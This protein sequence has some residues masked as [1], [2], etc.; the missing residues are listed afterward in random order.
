MKKTIIPHFIAFI[1][2]TSIFMSCSK[3]GSLVNKQELS[4][5]T[6][7]SQQEGENKI[8]IVITTGG[9]SGTLYPAPVY[10]EIIVFKEDGLV[11]KVLGRSVA[12]ERGQFIVVD[13]PEGK[14]TLLLKY[15]FNNSRDAE[16]SFVTRNIEII[17]GKVTDLGTILLTQ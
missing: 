10:A 3:D 2:L 14:C 15:T 12:D 17:I 8:P 9:I 11:K 6:V 7:A 4:N 16:Y 1:L 13:L 5:T